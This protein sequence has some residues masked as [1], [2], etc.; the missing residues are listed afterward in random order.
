MAPNLIKKI[1]WCTV[2]THGSHWLWDSNFISWC[3]LMTIYVEFLVFLVDTLYERHYTHCFFKQNICY[4]IFY[5]R[6]QGYFPGK[7]FSWANFPGVNVI[8]VA[9]HYNNVLWESGS[10][11]LCG[12]DGFPIFPFEIWD[13]TRRRESRHNEPDHNLYHRQKTYFRQFTNWL[14]HGL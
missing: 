8:S 14:E 2:S 4:A 3:F 6:C 7:N 9:I 1:L 11:R 5:P 13:I 12:N 10:T